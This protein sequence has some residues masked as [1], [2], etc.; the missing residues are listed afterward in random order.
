MIINTKIGRYEADPRHQFDYSREKTLESVQTSLQRLKCQYIDVLQL[1]DPEF[2]PSLTQLMTETI[3][4][5]LVC[6]NKGWCKALGMTGYPLEVQYQILQVT[7]DFFPPDK[8]GLSV[9]DQCLTY[10]HFNLHNT[11]L[12][13]QPVFK[14]DNKEHSPPVSFAAFVRHCRMG[15]LA[16]A[17]LSMGLLAHSQ[18]PAWHPASDELKEACAQASKICEAQ[19]VDLATIAVV[20]ALA[21]A[22]IPCTILGIKNRHEAN[23]AA[24]IANRFHGVEVLESRSQDEIL[25]QI[26]TQNEY[27]VWKTLSDP[28]EG[29]FAGVWKNG[30]YRWDGIKAARDF[31]RQMEGTT[32]DEW[33]WTWGK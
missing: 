24:T 30:A 11:S 5:L 26:L 10:G 3:P 15:L 6:R 27:K 2:A 7:L 1:H 9:W 25:Q 28:N 16:A 22:R 17:P 14:I 23:L 31:W 32:I 18:P 13:S 12:V 21:D 4:T 29:P 8:D 19:S 33:Q 20:V